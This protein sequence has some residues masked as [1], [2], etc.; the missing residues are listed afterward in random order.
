MKLFIYISLF[1]T[2]I[3][4]VAFVVPEKKIDKLIAKVWKDQ[5]VEKTDLPIN[6]SSLVSVNELMELRID[7]ELIGY[8]CTATA[9]GCRVGGC[10]APS[11]AN[12]DSYETFDYIVI[13]DSDLKIQKV[14]IA[15]YRGDYGYE[16]CN[17]RWLRQ[18]I[19]STCGFALNE[20]V[21]GITGATVSASFL[22]NDLNEIGLA[23]KTFLLNA[24]C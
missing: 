21:D 16:I 17:R 7:G 4:L 8:A 13:Y 22:V 10:A 18:F 1:V 6:D 20:N 14:D 24:G 9:F 2:T 5:V 15:T 12:A 3:S 11:N 23:L 19:G